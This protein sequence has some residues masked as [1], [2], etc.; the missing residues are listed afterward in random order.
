MKETTK[1]NM[2]IA[3]SHLFSMK[4]ISD[5]Q[6]EYVEV[7]V[8]YGKRKTFGPVL[9]E[10]QKRF[11]IKKDI[12]IMQL[13]EFLISKISKES[14]ENNERVSYHMFCRTKLVLGNHG[15]KVSDLLKTG[16]SNDEAVSKIELSVIT[17]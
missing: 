15:E 8:S 16:E 1:N 3:S 6:S 12:K 14:S 5:R 2:V 9:Y 17:T 4:S 13:K 10:K 11:M 7:L